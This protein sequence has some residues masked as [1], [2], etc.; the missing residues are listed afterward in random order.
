MAS[1]YIIVNV[2]NGEVKKT[3][4]NKIATDLSHSDEHFVIDVPNEEV[5]YNG[6]Q[7]AIEDWN[8]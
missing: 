7:E 8:A 4:D 6:S 3:D 5:M 1:R 2:V